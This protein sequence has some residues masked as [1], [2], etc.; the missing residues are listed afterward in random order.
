M[1]ANKQQP[2]ITA[3][4]FSF[5]ISLDVRSVW[6]EKKTPN[7]VHIAWLSNVANKNAQNSMLLF[8]WMLQGKTWKTYR[9]DTKKA[10]EENI[11][12]S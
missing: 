10:R 6:T 11:F 7:A 12:E 3:I 4:P 1:K 5:W 2:K 9:I 8:E